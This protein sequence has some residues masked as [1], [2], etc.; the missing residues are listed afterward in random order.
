MQYSDVHFQNEFRGNLRQTSWSSLFPYW[1]M[2]DDFLKTI[3]EEI[4]LIKAQGIFR[5]LNIGVK[6]PVMLWQTSLNHK[7]YHV[8]TQLIDFDNPIQIQ[9]PFYKTWGT[10]EIITHNELSNL[11]IM[12]NDND[13]I[14]IPFTIPENA[15]ILLDLENQNFLINNQD[16]DVLQR[17]Q[18][19]PYFITSQNNDTYQK[20]TPLHN[21]IVNIFFSSQSTNINLDID[22]ILK[23]VV[24]ENEQNIEITSLEALPI[25]KVILYAEYDFPYNTNINGWKKVYEKKYEN[26]THVIYDMITTHFYTKKFYVEVW[27]KSIDYP[28]TVG[29]PAYQDADTSSMYHINSELDTLG[30]LLSLPRRIYKKDI[31]EEDYPYTFPIFYPF[32]IEQDYWYYQRLVNEYCYNDLAIDTVDI[33]DTNNTPVVRLHSINPFVE[34]FVVYSHSSVPKEREGINYHEYIPSVVSQ[35]DDKIGH[36]NHYNIENL[37]QYNDHYTYNNILRRADNNISYETYKSKPLLMWFNTTDL[38]SDINITGLELILD[39]ESTDNAITKYNDD[40]TSIFITPETLSGQIESSGHFELTRKNIVYGGQN[41]LFGLEYIPQNNLHVT[42]KIIIK[43]FNGSTTEHIAIPFIYYED[44]KI[45]D[46]IDD[47]YVLFYDANNECVGST[48]GYYHADLLKDKKSI[49]RYID[50]EVPQITTNIAQINIVSTTNDYHPFNINIDV[51]TAPP[52]ELT[53]EEIQRLQE[54]QTLIHDKQQALNNA[55]VDREKEIL[56]EELVLLEEELEQLNN[57]E[58]YY[59]RFNNNAGLLPIQGPLD[60]NSH[61][62]KLIINKEWDTGDLRD[63]LNEYGLY[64][65]YA[66]TNDNSN[67]ASTVLLHNATLRIYHTPKQSHFKLQTNIIQAS[68]LD[69]TATLELSI[70][71]NGEKPLNTHIDIINANNLKLSKNYINVD[72]LQSGDSITEIINIKTEPNI[73]D[74]VYDVV[75]I[76]EDEIR[77]NYVKIVSNGLV[78]TNVKLKPH[79]GKINQSINLYAEVYSMDNDIINGSPNKIEFYI[80]NFYIGD[81]TVYNNRTETFS[82]IPSDYPFITAG[83]FKLTAKFIG[84]KKY[85]TSYT[86]SN[87]F[88]DKNNITI[89][90]NAKDTAIQHQNYYINADVTY[91]DNN[92][93]QQPVEDGTITVFVNDNELFTKELVNGSLET[94]FIMEENAGEASI[95]IRYNNTDKYPQTE[96]KKDILIIGGDTK[97]TV[98]DIN[99]KPGD[100]VNVVAKVTDTND[101]VINDG[102]VDCEISYTYVE[103]D[104]EYTSIYYS[105]NNQKI[106]NGVYQFTFDIPTDIL[107]NDNDIKALDIKFVYHYNLNSTDSDLYSNSEGLGQIY[108][109]KGDV[110]IHDSVLFNASAYEP[111]GFYLQITD[112]NTGEPISDGE[113]QITIPMP[114]QTIVFSEKVD[115]DGGARLIYNPIQFTSDEWNELEKTRFIIC[116]SDPDGVDINYVDEH[117]QP[118]PFD[119]ET[120]P[121]AIYYAQNSD[122]YYLYDY[123]ESQDKPT[124]ELLQRIG[125]SNSTN[126]IDFTIIG[127]ELYIITQYDDEPEHVYIGEDGYL[128]ARAAND[129]LRQYSEGVFNI[130]IDYFSEYQYKNQFKDSKIKISIPEIDV[131]MHS[132]IMHYDNPTSVK[133]YV[134][135]YSWDNDT[136]TV[137][138]PNGELNYYFDGQFLETVEVIN[139]LATLSTNALYRIPKGKHLLTAHL[140]TDVPTYTH[141]LLDMQQITPTINP[142][143][144][145]KFSNKKSILYVDVYAL[146]G[147][148]VTG[149]LSISINDVEVGYV[150]LT[151]EENGHAE[152]SIDMPDLSNNDQI[153][154]IVYGGNNYI[155]SY[156]LEKILKPEKLTTTLIYDNNIESTS[157]NTCEIPIGITSADNDDISEGYVVMMAVEDDQIIAKTFITNNTGILVFNTPQEY[158]T[159]QYKLQYEN[160]TNYYNNDNNLITINVIEGYETVYADGNT[161]PENLG[162]YTNL[163]SAIRAVKDSGIVYLTNEEDNTGLI[164]NDYTFTKDVHIIGTNN[165][166]ITKDIANLINDIDDV[167]CYSKNDF[168]TDTLS[169]LYK[170]DFLSLSSL[171]INEYRL[172]DKNIYYIHNND[173]IPIYIID[174]EFYATSNIYKKH[175]AINI[176]NH[177]VIFENIIF[178]NEDIENNL[179]IYNNGDLK[180]INS[181]IN[182]N[183]NINNYNTLTINRS[184]IYGNITLSSTNVDLNNNWWGSNRPPFDVDNHIILSISSLQKPPVIGESVDVQL[185]LIGANGREYILPS[186]YFKIYADSGI[187]A[188]E[189]GKLTNSKII[190]QYN[191]AIKEGKVYGEVDNQI[192]SLDIYDYDRKTEVILEPI[193]KFPRDYQ[194]TFKAFVQSVADTFFKFDDNN[195]IIKQSNDINNGYVVFSLNGERIGKAY[196][197]NGLAE[198]PTYLSSNVYNLEDM[199]LK[200]EYVPSEYYFKSENSQYITIINDDDYCFV[201]CNNGDD[202]ND[203]SF[204]EPVKTISKA[205]TLNKRYILIKEGTYTNENITIDNNVNIEAYGNLVTLTNNIITN[206]AILNINGITFINNDNDIFINANEIYINNCIFHDNHSFIINNNNASQTEII[207]SVILDNNIVSNVNKLDKMEYCWFGTNNPNNP[208]NPILEDYTINKYYIMQTEQ[209]KNKIYMES[210]VLIKATLQH[211][212]DDGVIYQD[213]ETSLPLRIAYFTTDAGSLMPIK[214]YTYNKQAITLL[215]TND[216]IN[217]NKIIITTPKN[218]NYVNKPLKLDIYVEQSNGTAVQNGEILLTITTNNNQN[219]IQN[220][221]VNI[222]NGIATY[223]DDTIALNAGTYHMYCVYHDTNSSYK[224]EYTF[225]VRKDEIV[226]NN[227]N[228]DNYDH[229]YELNFSANVNNISNDIVEYQEVYCYVDDKMVINQETN[230]NKFTIINGKAFFNMRY[231]DIEA[232]MHTLKITNANCQSNYEIFTFETKFNVYEK[233]TTI[234]FNYNGIEQNV[235]TDLIISVTDDNNKIVNG[236]ISIYINDEIVEKNGNSNFELDNGA[237]TLNNVQLTQGQYSIVI[238]Y[239]GTPNYYQE[240]MYIKNDFNVG[241]H[242]V[243]LSI[244]KEETII[245]SI[246]EQYT[247]GFNVLD[248][249]NNIVKTGTIQLYINENPINDKPINLAEDSYVSYPFMVSYLTAGMHN[250]M[251]KYEDDTNAYL[252]TTIFMDMLVEKIDTNINIPQIET[253]PNTQ[254]NVYYNITYANNEDVNT[255]TLIAKLNNKV[256]GTA[257]VSDAI[258]HYITLNIPLLQTDTYDIVFEYHDNNNIYADNSITI[259][260]MIKRGDVNI[261]TSHDSYYPN[262]EFMFDIEITDSNNNIINNGFVSLYI[263]NVRESDPIEVKYGQ[264]RYPLILKQ[265]RNY[266][267]T[268]VYEENEYYKETKQTQIIT[269][270]NIQIMDITIQEALQALPDTNHNYHLSFTT[271]DNYNVYDGIIDFIFDGD[272]LHSYHIQESNKEFN[273]TIPNTYSGNHV[274]EIF[275]HD[276]EIFKNYHKEF[277]FEILQKTLTLTIHNNEPINVSLDN[278]IDIPVHID[279]TTNGLIKFYLYDARYIN[280]NEY[281]LIENNNP[282]FAGIEQIVEED[283]VHQY[284]LPQTLSNNIYYVKAIF[285]GNNQYQASETTC[286]LII[287]P[288][289]PHLSIANE[290]TAEYQEVINI[291]VNAE[292]T[293]EP[294]YFYINN[295][296]IGEQLIKNY[297]CVY[298]CPLTQEYVEGDYEIKV[299]Y[300]GTP[301]IEP[302]TIYSQL[303]INKFTPI[304]KTLEYETNIGGH[305]QLD[306]ILLN[307]QNQHITSGNLECIY[308]NN[309]IQVYPS[310][311]KTIDLDPSIIND[312]TIQIS[313]TPSQ[314]NTFNALND[315]DINVHLIKNKLDI[316]M[317]TI[318]EVYRG[319]IFDVQF[320]LTN[321][322]NLPINLNGFIDNTPIDIID[323]VCNAQ[324][325]IDANQ[326]YQRK[327]SFTITIPES[328]I[329]EKFTYTFDVLCKNRTEIYVDYNGENDINT[330]NTIE[331]GLDLVSDNGTIYLYSD[332]VDKEININKRVHLVGDNNTTLKN[333]ILNADSS[334]ELRDIICQNTII[335]TTANTNINHCQ[336]FDTTNNVIYVDDGELY[337]NDSVFANNNA[338]NGACIYVSNKNKNTEIKKCTFINNSADI[339]GGAIYSDKG[340]NVLINQCIFTQNSASNGASIY[341]NGNAT[342]SENS[343]YN[344]DA[345]SEIMVVSGTIESMLNLFDGKIYTF[346]NNGYITSNMCYWGNND[347]II[348]ENKLYNNNLNNNQIVID[349]WLIEDDG[350]INKYI[351]KEIPDV[352]TTIDTISYQFEFYNEPI[353]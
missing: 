139:G 328:D 10:I 352:T 102:Y 183:I 142:R 40:R 28:Y 267:I 119:D 52:I 347:I 303:H 39:A 160:G 228:I 351:T 322:E 274:L 281:E 292:I 84:A 337:I 306:N 169:A 36:T 249:F 80:N 175:T 67:S 147:F 126:L 324:L 275:Y 302:E 79:F 92:N 11:E 184:L 134:T 263:D 54:L 264:V 327:Y 308:N 212:Y 34:D 227:I 159:Y 195:N 186:P 187:V 191:D 185:Q 58:K 222:H 236:N 176:N 151:G 220:Q 240:S 209:S 61:I 37:L 301:I 296:Y 345:I 88:I 75:T 258:N 78:K 276:S 326:Q 334:L 224:S 293:N 128:Y 350:I 312:F 225:D 298:E 46:N 284:Q 272:L 282:K 141:V 237:Y 152:F 305:L 218:V 33:V 98:F 200:A 158:G 149:D 31:D 202:N 113:V 311:S 244:P 161:D 53:N 45:I 59:L 323:G 87:I 101:T 115:E 105:N 214:D 250:V 266:P 230:R 315:I 257:Q 44:D 349:S 217:T 216:N 55:T 243:H 145:R 300:L 261:S 320:K 9:A 294:L 338:I 107:D 2:E 15:H 121:Y 163:I 99:G 178:N 43:P 248:Y 198:L 125:K 112:A 314:D 12:L 21:E 316:D 168:D 269:A 143:F 235:P 6:P 201:S 208:E 304:V 297:Q 205:L 25:E 231:N 29:F 23:N 38:P 321:D 118:I 210:V 14:I 16:I 299:Q 179:L 71:N 343:F 340:N 285:E 259:P 162:H 256:I 140:L 194:I 57:K 279:N 104:I 148:E 146:N 190:T 97:V 56:E 342:I 233:P 318:P 270:N 335:H 83:N 166:T 339:Y 47:V 72:N 108:V 252:D 171:N 116:D 192:V 111:L 32:D 234:H 62:N 253:Q 73:K 290:I 124:C 196:V 289:S 268:I 132:Y 24:F 288:Q 123:S 13:G 1:Y 17:G 229:V 353:L 63:L 136:E 344:N 156:T 144:N 49:Y 172:I 199:L 137:W 286:P 60:N 74:G 254:T 273:I 221:K 245:T 278:T 207:N 260:L 5:L 307:N 291:I 27:F 239:H 223:I 131:D 18:G 117:N 154:K 77:T 129:S 287:T 173:L 246:G 197:Q 330:A 93:T 238:Y 271:M 155:S 150:L 332:I 41:E 66:L 82:I 127:D 325:I 331:K 174:G 251:I 22:I 213:T 94:Y 167:Q 319:D 122:L 247:F 100:T 180:I 35:I 242:Q 165:A 8:N 153:L 215:N 26:D 95:T 157:Q 170:I 70:T 120:H 317:R 50:V 283:I 346:K 138:I 341:I 181:I 68:H 211:I 103:D 135:Q 91:I 76:C 310:V 265:I 182:K 188:H 20:D 69:N 336:F 164:I 130:V 96:I 109:K 193:N 51:S 90:L 177:N 189:Y 7:E 241:M 333:V 262:Q 86:N 89:D 133:S 277:T 204:G 255:G 219:I 206:N 81:A 203:G 64:F 110:I 85:A 329:F 42:Q 309:D 232:G 48:H 19:L 114:Q 65:N 226:F 313:Y 106:I 280:D 30:E 295:K 4:E 3:G 348:I